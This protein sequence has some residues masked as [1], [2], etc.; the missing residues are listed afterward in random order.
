MVISIICSF[1]WVL[2]E[3]VSPPNQRCP[4]V[5]NGGVSHGQL[6]RQVLHLHEGGEEPGRGAPEGHGGDQEGQLP[7]GLVLVVDDHLLSSKKKMA[8]NLD[9][10][11]LVV[12]DHLLLANLVDDHLLL[13]ANNW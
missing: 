12:D 1:K 10:F 9:H 11:N 5:P 3:V 13:I 2:L 7:G 8:K 6:Q 4:T